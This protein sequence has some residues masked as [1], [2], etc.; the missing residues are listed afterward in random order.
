MLALVSKSVYTSYT[1]LRKEDNAVTIKEAKFY[2]VVAALVDELP[3]LL[4]VYRAYD[5]YV[6]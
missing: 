1:R 5:I 3:L 2:A 4:D 6:V